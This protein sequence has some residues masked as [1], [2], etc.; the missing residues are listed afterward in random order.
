MKMWLGVLLLTLALAVMLVASEES[1]ESE[2]ASL[3][4]PV[5]GKKPC[6]AW[7]DPNWWRRD[8]WRRRKRDTSAELD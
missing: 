2:E 4:R 8:C 7:F 6:L 3:E 5:R 1:E